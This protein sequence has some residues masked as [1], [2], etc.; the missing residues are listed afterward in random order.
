[1]KVPRNRSVAQTRARKDATLERLSVFIQPSPSGSSASWKRMQDEYMLDIFQGSAKHVPAYRQ[2]LK[3]KGFLAKTVNTMT[4]FRHIPPVSKQN[5]L[6]KFPWEDLCVPGALSGKSLVLTATSGS[7]GK[8]FYFPRTDS[9]DE[10]SYIMHRTFLKN[11]G[12]DPA[13]P[14]LVIVAF[15][16]GVW[17]GG[18]ITY[19]AFNRISERDFPLTILTTGVNKKEIYDALREIGPRYTQLVLCGYPPFIK[20]VIDDGPENG[21]QWKQFDMR[22][23]C[24]A[25]GFSEDF[26]DYLLRKTGM[27][28]AY[29]DVMNIYGSA[30][31]GTMATETPLAIL[32]RK[33]T[34]AHPLL[35]T[36]LFTEATRLP[37][38]AQF[39]P[40]FVSFEAADNRIYCT[41]GNALPL[42]R[43]EIGDHGGVFTYSELVK[44]CREEGIDLK[45]EIRTAGISDTVA[46]LPFVYIYERADLSTKLYGAIIFPEHVKHGLMRRELERYVTTK[47]TMFT[48]TDAKQDEYLEVNVELKENV[49]PTP[50]LQH[51]VAEAIVE[52]LMEKS[53]EHKNNVG[54][55]GD[56]VRPR[57]VFWAHNHHEHFAHG[58]KHKWVKKS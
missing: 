39:V 27:R 10:Q 53:A 47:F 14:T 1:M 55:L 44:A 52:S 34:L 29:R 43:Y 9:I 12:L 26:R 36:R 21:V 31:L 54:A 57:V 7:T 42:I 49:K 23:V 8:P 30:E 41:A 50:E 46:E 2:F 45:N 38:L 11:S 6:K 28:D 33:L 5:Y 32:V 4:D 3:E 25:E 51:T 37:T 24:A 15:G 56:R 13:E 58:G 16:M 17:I 35:F 48:K 22:I 40:T 18:L 20:D 19:E